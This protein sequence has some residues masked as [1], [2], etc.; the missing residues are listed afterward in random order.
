MDNEASLPKVIKRRRR[1]SP[2]FK[3]RVVDECRQANTSIAEV[4]LRHGLNLNQ[5]HMAALTGYYSWRRLCTV[6]LAHHGR[7]RLQRSASVLYC[8]HSTG[9]QARYD[10]SVLPLREIDCSIAW[11]KALMQ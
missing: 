8:Q 2:A 11:L 7:T 3:Q 5:V 10:H 1:H 4:A 6:A 9:Q